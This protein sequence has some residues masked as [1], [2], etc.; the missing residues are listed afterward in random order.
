MVTAKQKAWR[1]RFAEMVRSG[2]FTKRKKVRVISMVRRKKYGFKRRGDGMGSLIKGAIGGIVGGFASQYVPIDVPMKKELSS[3]TGGYL[4][5]K[6][7][8]GAIAGVV[9]DKLVSPMLANVLATKTS[10]TT[11][12]QVYY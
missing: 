5:G 7:L 10:A 8:K 4:L 11:P 6:G 12:S 9:A 3:A 2:K 1:A